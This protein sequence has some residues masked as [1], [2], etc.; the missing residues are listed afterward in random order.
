MRRIK[1]FLKT[2]KKPNY[3]QV[4][5]IKMLTQLF[6]LSFNVWTYLAVSVYWSQFR[7]T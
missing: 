2:T 4:L 5:S 3:R 6:P 1:I 7:I